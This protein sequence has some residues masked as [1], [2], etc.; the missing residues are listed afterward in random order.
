MTILICNYCGWVGDYTEL[1]A[2]T[3]KNTYDPNDRKFN[4]CPD[5]ESDDLEDENEEED[6][7]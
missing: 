4:Y 5:C 3:E 6:W 7:P 1:I 2:K